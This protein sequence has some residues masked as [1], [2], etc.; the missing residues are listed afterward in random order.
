M[1][2]VFEKLSKNLEESMLLLLR[3][4]ERVSVDVMDDLDGKD[5]LDIPDPWDLVDER[6]DPLRLF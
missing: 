5:D 1:A 3:S 4:A 6:R 2:K